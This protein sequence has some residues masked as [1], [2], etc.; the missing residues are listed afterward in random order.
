MGRM[1]LVADASFLI[2]LLNPIE[3]HHGVAATLLAE[4]NHKVLVHP[5][6]LAEVLVGV[7][8]T[9]REASLLADFVSAG[10]SPA[11][12]DVVDALAIARVRS[13]S[14]LKMPDAI[15]LATALALSAGLATFDIRLRS[16]A[17]R[18]GVSLVI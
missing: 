7:V 11:P 5:V 13:E 14:G 4:G 9:G 6:T 17:Q 2:A 16:A 18:R 3:H 10:V 8:P 15:V 1:T 12:A